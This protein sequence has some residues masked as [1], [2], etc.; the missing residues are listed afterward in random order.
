MYRPW[1]ADMIDKMEDWR[2]GEDLERSY[3]WS[4]TKRNWQESSSLFVGG[5]TEAARSLS[6][7]L[8]SA[9]Y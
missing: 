4:W 2:K 9:G 6:Y 8:S 7:I 5:N 1:M 3:D